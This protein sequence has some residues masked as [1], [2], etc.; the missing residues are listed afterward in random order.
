MRPAFAVH[1][2]QLPLPNF[3][4]PGSRTSLV[5][6]FA[7]SMLGMFPNRDVIRVSLWRG[8]SAFA[9]LSIKQRGLSLGHCLVKSLL[10][11]AV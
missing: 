6:I 1:P 5:M 3:V 9:L 8:P 7:P 10:K 2:V 4:V 11:L